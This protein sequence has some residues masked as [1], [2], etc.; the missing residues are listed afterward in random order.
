M[1]ITE[2]IISK[3]CTGKTTLTPNKRKLIIIPTLGSK[4]T[5]WGPVKI[6]WLSVCIYVSMSSCM[7]IFL[8]IIW[9]DR[10]CA[11]RI[12]PQAMGSNPLIVSIIG[13]SVRPSVRPSGCPRD[14]CDFFICI[15]FECGG[16]APQCIYISAPPYPCLSLRSSALIF[17]NYL[18]GS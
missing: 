15:I 17:G 12:R 11:Q 3:N 1:D 14:F 6:I 13:L 5:Q 8:T 18:R 16:P 2:T 4:G 9:V 10:N 7:H